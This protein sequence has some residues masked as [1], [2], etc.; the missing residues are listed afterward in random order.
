EV[1]GRMTYRTVNCDNGRYWVTEDWLSVK[2]SVDPILLPT[3]SGAQ[4]WQKAPPSSEA[5]MAV[6]A[7]CYETKSLF[8]VAWDTVKEAYHSP[9]ARIE[10][11]SPTEM[12][13]LGMVPGPNDTLFK[14]WVGVT[15]I[16]SRKAEQSAN[17][18]LITKEYIH[19][20]SWDKEAER[21]KKDTNL[22]IAHITG[23][24]LVRGGNYEQLKQIQLIT[25]TGKTVISFS[26]GE[27]QLAENV[28]AALLKAG[29]KEFTTSKFVHGYRVTKPQ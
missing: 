19:F 17:H 18:V 15:S 5:E 6:D 21:F 20:I 23:V 28:Y 10:D 12:S 29:L 4:E 26:T 16:D 22:P 3:N 13:S 2:N 11:I 25:P 27:D 14:A 7:L 24:A 8:G 1:I 9:K